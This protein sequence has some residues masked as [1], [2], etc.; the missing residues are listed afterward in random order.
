MNKS[1]SAK[2]IDKKTQDLV[3]TELRRGTSKSRIATLL[4]IPYDEAVEVIKAV[5]E[6][7]R[8]EVGDVVQFKFRGY[9]IVGEIE[10][11]LNNSAII[12]IF[13]DQS[14]REMLDVLEERTA[15]NFKDIDSFVK[16]ADNA[17]KKS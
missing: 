17:D 4:D 3:E 16:T 2:K 12:K 10:K 11:L 8:P 15:V 14:D 13:W 1:K 7:V 6:N 9:K 5:K